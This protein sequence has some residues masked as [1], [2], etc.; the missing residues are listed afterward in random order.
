MTDLFRNVDISLLLG[1]Q[2]R[3][4]ENIKDRFIAR[5]LLIGFHIFSE[6]LQ[7]LSTRN[8]SGLKKVGWLTLMQMAAGMQ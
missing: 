4:T 8:Q 5:C 7:C 1:I 3:I 2:I 6:S